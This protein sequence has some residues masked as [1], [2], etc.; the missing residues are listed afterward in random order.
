MAEMFDINSERQKRGLPE[1]GG[2]QPEEFAA[3]VVRNFNTDAVETVEEVGGTFHI[4]NYDEKDLHMILNVEQKNPGQYSKR[5]LYQ[6][7]KEYLRLLS[8]KKSQQGD[9]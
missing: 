8:D 6:A 4:S 3:N 5:F 1:V 2:I 9:R 7:A